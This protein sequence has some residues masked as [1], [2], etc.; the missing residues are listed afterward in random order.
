MVEG[1]DHCEAYTAIVWGGILSRERNPNAE[2]ETVSSVEGNT[3]T[4]GMQGTA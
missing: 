2:A 3:G 4:A 1:D